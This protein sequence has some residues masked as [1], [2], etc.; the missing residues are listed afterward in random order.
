[1]RSEAPGIC[2]ASELSDP[3]NGRSSC[4]LVTNQLLADPSITCA[5]THLDGRCAMVQWSSGEISN[6]SLVGACMD[7][8]PATRATWEVCDPQTD[9]CS[10]GSL[11]LPEDLFAANPSGATR[12]VP[13][14]D[15]EHHDG[16]QADCADLGA[17]PVDNATP[18]CQSLSLLYP[19]N[20][21]LDFYP[22]RLGYCAL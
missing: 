20:G 4:S 17:Q 1:V 21:P 6:G 9:T 10:P 12:C 7:Y 15:T 22:T 8:L 14:C 16:L 3:T 2:Y 18:I 13:F 19:P 11:C 5:D